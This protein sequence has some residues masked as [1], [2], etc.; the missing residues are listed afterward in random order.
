MTAV[1]SVLAAQQHTAVLPPT[2]WVQD[3]Q[4]IS[5]QGSETIQPQ[6]SAPSNTAHV[7]ALL[8]SNSRQSA[9]RYRKKPL[10]PYPNSFDHPEAHDLQSRP[11]ALISMAT[12]NAIDKEEAPVTHQFPTHIFPVSKWNLQPPRP[13]KATVLV[14]SNM[15]PADTMKTQIRHLLKS[16]DCG[17]HH[18][19]PKLLSVVKCSKFLSQENNLSL[20]WLCWPTLYV[21]LFFFLSLQ[22][23]ATIQTGYYLT[24]VNR[25]PRACNATCF[26]FSAHASLSDCIFIWKA[27][28]NGLLR[29]LRNED[30][31]WAHLAWKNLLVFDLWH[32]KL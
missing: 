3:K 4:S 11:E 20:G 22:T 10:C 31:E 27:I 29:T 16:L 13:S 32:L 9:G 2:S 24:L 14:K 21:I 30:A 8:Q 23:T 19:C 12:F 7:C 28:K 15:L 18:I 25:T 1:T 26:L 5:I 17:N 6:L